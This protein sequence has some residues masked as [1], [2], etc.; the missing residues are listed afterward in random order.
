[1]GWLAVM[2]LE[3][4]DAQGMYRLMAYS[5]PALLL[6]IGFFY[7]CSQVWFAAAAASLSNMILIPLLLADG[8]LAQDTQNFVS[9][10]C[11]ICHLVDVV[12]T[13]MLLLGITMTLIYR[14]PVGGISMAR[15][16]K[17]AR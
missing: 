3:W 8:T 11:F 7:T 16:L 9:A 6:G 14:E 5:L 2:I 17:V 13:F 12:A 10:I 1:M 15:L 4:L